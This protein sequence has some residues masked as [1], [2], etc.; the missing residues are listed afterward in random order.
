M[1]FLGPDRLA[2]LFFL[3][4]MALWFDVLV[5]GHFYFSPVA[6]VP[7]GWV[8]AG[9]RYYLPHAAATTC[10]APTRAL[11]TVACLAAYR[12]HYAALPAYLPTAC[13]FVAAQN[14]TRAPL[15]PLPAF[16]PCYGRT[17]AAFHLP[18]QPPHLLL[19]PA[20]CMLLGLVT[21]YGLV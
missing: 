2:Y 17:A 11:P 6:M 8:R 15:P 3:Y 9:E 13:V 21:R 7:A 20:A 19:P 14:T 5:D 12:C 4:C 1:N 16:T 10:G 18:Y